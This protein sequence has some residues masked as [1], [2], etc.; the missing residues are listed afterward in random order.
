[1][2]KLRYS[3]YLLSLCQA[4]LQVKKLK[5]IL[6]IPEATI[7]SVRINKF[8]SICWLATVSLHFENRFSS[9]MLNKHLTEIKVSSLE[10]LLIDT[11]PLYFSLGNWFSCW[12]DLLL[13]DVTL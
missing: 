5:N 10:R 12:A 6:G 3:Q 2:L 8:T 9:I 4:A 1:M 13:L 11:S 7:L